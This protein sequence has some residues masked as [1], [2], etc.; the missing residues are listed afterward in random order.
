M[1]GSR[2]AV[3]KVKGEHTAD[4]VVAGV[5]WS[6]K[7]DRLASLMLAL[8]E[9]GE[10]RP[11]GTRGR[12]RRSARRSTRALG[13][14]LG[15]NPE[16][17]PRGEP[18]RWRPN[19]VAR[20]V[21]GRAEA[22]RRGALRQ[23]AEAALPPRHEASPL[24]RGQGSG[25]VHGRPGGAEAEEGRPHRAE[26]PGSLTADVSALPCATNLRLCCITR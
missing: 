13:P 4:C 9:D 21:A 7:G 11:V 22:R 3:K 2:E 6:E 14:L 18:S 17:K 12:R 19:V 5:T 8:Y 23:V 25:P 15:K 26:A 20:V 1:P 24:P 10:L 16:R